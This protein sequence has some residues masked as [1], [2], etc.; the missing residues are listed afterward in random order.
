MKSCAHPPQNP[1]PHFSTSPLDYGDVSLTFGSIKL[2]ILKL[3]NGSRATR[4]LEQDFTLNKLRLSIIGERRPADAGAEWRPMVWYLATF[5]ND[6]VSALPKIYHHFLVAVHSPHKPVDS[7]EEQHIHTTPERQYAS[8]QW[9]FATKGDEEGTYRTEYTVE[10]EMTTLMDNINSVRS[11]QWAALPKP[12]QDRLRAQFNRHLASQAKKLLLDHSARP[13]VLFHCHILQQLQ[14]PDQIRRKQPSVQ[15]KMSNLLRD[16]P[17]P[18][19]WGRSRSSLI[20]PSNHSR[21]TINV[22]TG[23]LTR[24]QLPQPRHRP[25]PVNVTNAKQ[26]FEYL[27][28]ESSVACLNQYA[29]LASTSPTPPLSPPISVH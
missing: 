27:P 11:H 29:L 12:V 22:G 7:Y 26:S 5:G 1:A 17:L 2:P 10:T 8:Q 13:P 4:C 9:R 28:L 14:V 23:S 21:T 15:S 19:A 24:E 6:P 20:A 18:R 16:Y 3:L 25:P